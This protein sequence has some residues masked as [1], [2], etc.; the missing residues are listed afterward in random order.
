MRVAPA[1]GL[2]ASGAGMA[3]DEAGARDANALYRKLENDVLPR[4]HGDRGAGLTSC[5]T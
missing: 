1:R 2:T 3:A 5:G 4:L